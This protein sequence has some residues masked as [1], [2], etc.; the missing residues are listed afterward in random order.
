MSKTKVLLK[1]GDY[2]LVPVS[3]DA[4]VLG[5]LA[6]KPKRRGVVLVYFWP[7]LLRSIPSETELSQITLSDKLIAWRVGDSE[8]YNGRWRV[9]GMDREFSRSKWPFPKFVRHVGTSE[10]AFVLTYSEDDPSE[11]VS[12]VAIPAGTVDLAPAKMYGAIAAEREILRR[13]R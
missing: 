12:E 11:V 13:L 9:V 1:E 10:T 4:H 8:L 7:Q 6:R 5:L 2:F 3:E